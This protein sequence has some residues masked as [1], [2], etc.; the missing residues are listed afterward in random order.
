MQTFVN[1]EFFRGCLCFPPV[2]AQC[3]GLG[4]EIG[5][6]EAGK[7]ADILLV[8]GNPLADITM[9]QDQA[10]ITVYKQGTLVLWVKGQVTA[11]MKLTALVDNNTFART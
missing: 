11:D 1:R 9:L 10:R 6:L 7:L 5:T 3:C 8:D 4:E 2:A